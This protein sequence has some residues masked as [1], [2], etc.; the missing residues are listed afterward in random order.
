[1]NALVL[2]KNLVMF[3]CAT[4]ISLL[5]LGLA[6]YFITNSTTFGVEGQART[7]SGNCT[8]ELRTNGFSPTTQQNGDLTL[9]HAST[10]EIERSVY[11]ASASIARCYGYTVKHFCAGTGCP[12]PG[13][14]FVLTT[15]KES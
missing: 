9:Y 4:A 11:K 3:L 12:K 5:L 13:V 2:R 7:L 6:G 14:T 10:R 15:S 8:T 1:M